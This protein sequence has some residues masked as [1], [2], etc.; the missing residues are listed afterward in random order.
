MKL[1]RISD[2]RSGHIRLLFADG[3]VLKTLPSVVA[4]FDLY[5][6][7]ELD[8]S[9]MQA[10]Q[11]AI[12]AFSAKE[13]AVHIVSAVGVSE[14][15]LRKR[16]VQKGESEADAENAVEWLKDLALLDDAR[17]AEQIVN[18]AVSKG[19]GKSRIRNLLYEKGIPRSL[20][21]DA[22]SLV[23]EMDDAIDRFLKQR[24]D[25]REIDDKLVKKTV[26]ALLRK[27]HSYGDIQNAL[28][29]Y[30]TDCEFEPEFDPE[31]A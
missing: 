8:E 22:L 12:C 14:K 21:D 20:W 6:G 27:G 10:L 3:S 15:E 4:G 26:D 5:D 23:P 9:Q 7:K 30:R 18:S 16:L 29:R 11:S 31:D 25:G 24:L 2:G 19:Y 28:R 1:E 17:T 13:R